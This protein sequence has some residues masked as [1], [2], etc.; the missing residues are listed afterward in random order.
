[1]EE[2]RIVGAYAI[3]FRIECEHIWP[4]DFRSFPLVDAAEIR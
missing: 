1:M 4:S 2:M 3:H